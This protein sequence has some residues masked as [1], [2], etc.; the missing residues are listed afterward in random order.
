MTDDCWNQIG[1]AGDRTCRQLKKYIHCR[2]CPVYSDGGRS[3]L[4]QK[5]PLG[6]L[7]EWT[8]VLRS[9]P[10]VTNPKTSTH[11]ISVGIFRLRDEWLALPAALFK[12]VTQLSVTHTL[13]HRSNPILI[14]LVN[15]RGELQLCISLTALL[16]LETADSHRKNVSLVVYER[17]VV[18]EKEG[19]RWVFVVDEMHGIHRINLE[20]LRNVPATVS[21]VPQTYTKGI[22]TWQGQN[23]CY[24][25]DDLLFDSLNNK[26]I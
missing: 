2:N 7:D 17:M 8:Q 16:G 24:L 14:G 13:P 23:V 5:L 6:Y 15:I 22:I 25:N 10:E 26:I 11:T 19:S 9:T 12:E 21:K 18:V 3:L 20:E 1:I 4:E